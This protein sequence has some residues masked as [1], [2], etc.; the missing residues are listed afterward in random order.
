MKN[1]NIFNKQFAGNG[2]VRRMAV[3]N[4]VLYAAVGS[5][6]P[7]NSLRIFRLEHAGCKIWK[8]ITPGWNPSPGTYDLGMAAYKGELYVGTRNAE[9]FVYNPNS[10]WSAPQKLSNSIT[11][12]MVWNNLLFIAASGDMYSTSDGVTYTNLGAVKSFGPLDGSDGT[13]TIASFGNHIYAGHGCYKTDAPYGKKVEEG[14]EI[15]RSPDGKKWTLFKSL[16]SK[17]GGIGLS[18]TAPM[19]VHAMLGFKNHL[20]I[21]E[22]EGYGGTVFRTD[23][24]AGSW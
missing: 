21:G 24:S 18:S 15:W 11:S 19:H 3:I 1:Q 8:D 4:G 7:L 22:Y 14:I 5:P 10:G 17:I 16:T 9:V 6:A 20:Y 2:E 13:W 12:M 23:G